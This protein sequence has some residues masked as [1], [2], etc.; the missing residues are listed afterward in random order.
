MTGLTPKPKPDQ[1]SRARPS[2][3]RRSSTRQAMWCTVPTATRPGVPVGQ[4]DQIDELARSN[5]QSGTL[6]KRVHAPFRHGAGTAVARGPRSTGVVAAVAT[7]VAVTPCRPRTAWL[8]GTGLAGHACQPGPVAASGPAATNSKRIPSGSAKAMT[9]SPWRSISSTPATPV[10]AQP[11]APIRNGILRNAQG[12][13]RHLTD[14]EAAAARAGPGEKRQDRARRAR[15]VAVVEVVRARVIE[16]DRALDQA[17]TQHAAVE[18]EVA[19]RV[20]AHGGDM[21]EANDGF[22]HGTGWKFRT[23]TR[24]WC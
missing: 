3:R 21:M 18:V 23:R 22:G 20:A 6:A 2:A 11:L 16:V 4:F 8:S 24:A 19:L 12:G 1:L 9:C 10:F 7:S 5:S 17:Q 15:A 14:A 13:H